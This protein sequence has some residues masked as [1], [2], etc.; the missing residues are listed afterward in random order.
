MKQ[1][2]TNIPELKEPSPNSRGPRLVLRTH[3]FGG[4]VPCVTRRFL[5]TA[6]E[7]IRIFVC[8]RK[9]NAVI[10]LKILGAIVQNLVARATWRPGARDMGH[11][12]VKNDL[13]LELCH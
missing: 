4:R 6:C 5:F 9:T 12:S 13:S 7:F 2:F 8:K 10:M 11:P 1:E 3:S